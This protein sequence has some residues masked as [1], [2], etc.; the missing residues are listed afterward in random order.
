MMEKGK[1]IEEW[2]EM[3]AGRTY[4]YGWLLYKYNT[5]TGYM[6]LYTTSMGTSAVSLSDVSKYLV[7]TG[8]VAY[9]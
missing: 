6:T 9:K 3:S 7:N 4:A 2:L 8:F 1:I 5:V